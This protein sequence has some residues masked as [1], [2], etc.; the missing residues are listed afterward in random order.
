MPSLLELGES[1]RLLSVSRD[2]RVGAGRWGVGL[3]RTTPRLSV[4]LALRFSF[5]DTELMGAR[6]R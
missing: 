4:R 3:W 6:Q 2:C 1:R 5:G